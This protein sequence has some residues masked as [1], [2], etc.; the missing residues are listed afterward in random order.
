MNPRSPSRRRFLGQ[1]GCAALSS[2]SMLNMLLNLKLANHAAAQDSPDDRKT[3]VCLFLHGGNDSFN[4]FVPRDAARHAVYASARGNL[5]LTQASLRPLNQDSGGDG[6]LYGLHPSCVGFQELFNGLGGDTAK[7]RLSIITNIGTLIQPVNKA[8][9]LAESVPLPRA[10]FSHSD[11]I[12][13]WQTSVPQGLAQ[14]SGW[15]GRAADVM[16]DSFNS[17]Q[18]AMGIS[19]SGNNLYQVGNNTQQFVVTP[20]GALTFTAAVGGQPASNPLTVKNTAHRSLIEQHYSNLVQESFGQL[21]K[22]SLDLQEHFQTIFNTYDASAIEPL[23][24]GNNYLGNDLLAIAKIIA[25]R[26]QLGLRRQTIFLTYG[27]WD[28]HAEL[29]N[30]Q[31]GMLTYLD[32]ALTAFQRALEA[33]NLQNDVITFTCS[34]FARTLRS[35]GNGTDH[36]WG[37]NA[38]VMG[39]PVQGGRVLGSFP[40]LALEGNDDVGYGGRLIPTTSV[41]KFFAELL[42]WF[43]VTAANMPYVLPNIAN[44]YNVNSSTLPLGFLRPGTWM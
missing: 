15:G 19:L 7:R 20:G 34:D 26:Q 23:F 14:L 6:H 24:P 17:G 16:H 32:S 30:T 31:A 10:L 12:D 44:F 28:H 36:A 5:A 35:N 21:T 22:T 9:Y 13:Q 25:L 2:V 37:G 11:Q 40:D 1:A 4:M 39:G 33:L 27:G 8:Q 41:D 38:L 29:L 42:R 18:T 3:L 43:G